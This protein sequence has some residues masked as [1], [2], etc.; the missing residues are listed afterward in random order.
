MG[1]VLVIDPSSGS[2]SSL[3]GY[4]LFEKGELKEVGVLELNIGRELGQRLKQLSDSLREFG[5]VD[6][7]VIE[8]IPVR[9]FGKGARPHASLLK[10]VGCVMGSVSYKHLVEVSP[11]T[12]KA[13][14]KRN[15]GKFL[16]YM[17]SDDWDALIMG[18]CSL[19]RAMGQTFWENEK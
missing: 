2:Q 8:D 9:S 5:E 14:L 11:S 18:Y 12:W 3:P 10:A 6:V 4:A 15:E 7:L 17:K 13:Y 19:D 16:N 1:K